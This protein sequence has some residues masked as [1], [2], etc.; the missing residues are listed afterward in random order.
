MASSDKLT[1]QAKELRDTQGISLS[2]AKR[3][4][5]SGGDGYPWQLLGIDDIKTYDPEPRWRASTGKGRLPVVVGC[6]V[7]GAPVVLDLSERP[8][9][10][11][12]PHWLI[13]TV[14]GNDAAGL[15]QFVA[16][17]LAVRY[18]P[19]RLQMAV[20]DGT[21]AL[22]ALSGL[23]H[24]AVDSVD[25]TAEQWRTWLDN[26]V[27][28]RGAHLNR[29][30]VTADWVAYRRL[31][32]ALQLLPELVVFIVPG[33]NDDIDAQLIGDVLTNGHGAG[34]HVILCSPEWHSR[35]DGFRATLNMFTPQ[36][37][38]QAAEF[39]DQLHRE[40][41]DAI[42]VG[43]ERDLPGTPVGSGVLHVR[44]RSNGGNID[45]DDYVAHNLR[46]N[47][48]PSLTELARRLR[49]VKAG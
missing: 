16:A 49:K 32:P 8:F 26:T 34:V 6:S 2:E 12:G 46:A 23:P 9:G 14:P 17:D 31:A 11:N 4:I 38:E 7:Q 41:P 3:Q 28:V 30:G 13:N 19:S 40:A 24:I 48:T 44:N 43:A 10:G 29:F 27:K 18:D 21:G 39:F 15:L 42:F 33:A 35:P 47:P 5:V 25:L 1:R 20:F 37:P 45:Y 22:R 36:T